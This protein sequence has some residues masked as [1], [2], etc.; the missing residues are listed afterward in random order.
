M[1]LSASTVHPDSG[2]VTQQARNL[3]LDLDDR[4]T[5]IRFLIHDRDTKFSRAFDEVVRSEGVRVILT[6][7][8]PER[9]C[10]R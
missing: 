7:I 1:H 3:A 2:W 4:S 10:L 8:G 5:A 9:Q 6:P